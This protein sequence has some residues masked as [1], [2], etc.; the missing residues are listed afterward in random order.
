MRVVG[1]LSGSVAVRIEGV[2]LE[3][4]LSDAIKK[5]VK[6]TRAYT[7]DKGL[8]VE[9][10]TIDYLRLKRHLKDCRIVLL[11]KSG[12]VK[13][14]ASI[15][16]RLGA[17]MLFI[18]VALFVY[19]GSLFI[20]EIS[21]RGN[22]RIPKYKIIEILRSEGAEVFSL[23]GNI[24]IKALE[25]KLDSSFSDIDLVNVYLKGS[26][27]IVDIIEGSP[28]PNVYSDEAC[29]IIA[30]Y[31]G[32]IQKVIVNSGQAC[33]K[34]YQQ[35]KKGDVLIRGNYTKGETSYS[36][37]S[38]G[39]IMA[40]VNITKSAAFN[41]EKSTNIRTGNKTVLKY[42]KIGEKWVRIEGDNTFKEYNY[43]KKLIGVVGENLPLSFKI[44]DVTCYETKKIEYDD[45][46]IAQIDAKERAYYLALKEFPDNTII[47]S[48]ASNIYIDDNGRR[49]VA[50]TLSAIIDICTEAEAMPPGEET[51]GDKS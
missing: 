24:D 1:V 32:I 39:S 9:L 27:L 10:S 43:N 12:L 35:V 40:I 19:I 6:I 48:V 18:M 21:V 51:V 7:K 47:N 26:K 13:H 16:T 49:N 14:V 41:E 33:V 8:V 50:V 42:L 5:G 44:Y 29:D 25:D 3:R 22:E 45:F 34:E 4:N 30:A 38:R 15:P 23:K 31:D 37:H 2:N 11:K 46:T 20:L 36:T 17:L 28:A